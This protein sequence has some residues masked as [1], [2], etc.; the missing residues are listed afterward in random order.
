MND[1]VYDLYALFLFEAGERYFSIF[2]HL[3]S[4]GAIDYKFYRILK[5]LKCMESEEIWISW[6]GR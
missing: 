1:L 6:Y 3:I 5:H 4:A 2:E